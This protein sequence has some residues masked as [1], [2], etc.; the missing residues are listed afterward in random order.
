M[1]I[2]LKLVSFTFIH[3]NILD[4]IFI[5]N[6][7]FTDIKRLGSYSPEEPRTIR[8]QVVIK[9]EKDSY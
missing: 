5:N 1:T 6:L 4:L 3:F 7:I 9:V 8:S 2:V